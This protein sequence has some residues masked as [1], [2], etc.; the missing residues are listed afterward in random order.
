M[1]D[2]LLHQRLENELNQQRA[3][4]QGAAGAAIALAFHQTADASLGWGLAPIALAV[5]AW[6]ISFA[7][8]ILNS[9]A[10]QGGVRCNIAWHDLESNGRIEEAN[11]LKIEFFVY[12]RKAQRTYRA[13]L[14]GLL[15]GAALYFVGHGFQLAAAGA[16]A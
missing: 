9:H 1:D 4:L 7:A 3:L 16:P 8:G 12:N 11:D 14:W 10:R 2:A 13:Q 5:V 15:I 6:A